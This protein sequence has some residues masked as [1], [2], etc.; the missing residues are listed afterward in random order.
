MVLLLAIGA[1]LTLTLMQIRR[2]RLDL[3]RRMDLLGDANGERRTAFGRGREAGAAGWLIAPGQYARR[4][5][6]AGLP[7]EWGMTAGAITLIATSL[8]AVA[9]SWLTFRYGMRLSILINLGISVAMSFLA[10]RSLL[11]YQQNRQDKQ[12]T[13]AFPDTI[14]MIIRMLRAG[15]PIT[16]AVRAVGQEAPPPVCDVF[17]NLADKMAIGISFEDALAAAGERIALNDF[18]FFAVAISLQRETGGNLTATLDILSDLMR[19]RRA[20]RLRARA[21]T[22]EVRMSALVLG[23]IPF[24]IIGGLLLMTPAYL[25]PL[26]ADPRGHII[27]GVACGSMLTGFAVIRQMMRSVTS[28]T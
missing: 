25:H 15:L 11:K 4:F 18:R 16:N 28:A 1:I 12:F 23:G 24:F 2:E 8:A 7:R 5:F 10:P 17:T 26:F 13:E 27:I 21:T 20:A 19:K 9:V 14:D 3:D 6:G 22:G